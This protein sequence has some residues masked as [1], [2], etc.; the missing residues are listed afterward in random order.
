MSVQLDPR[1]L[2][3]H[4]YLYTGTIATIPAGMQLCDGTNGTVDL[5]NRFVVCADADSGGEAKSTVTGAAAK[6]GNGQLISHDHTTF[7]A[8]MPGGGTYVAGGEGTYK[9]LGQSGG[10]T[11]GAWEPR[12]SLNGTGSVNVAVFYA[13]AFIQR[14]GG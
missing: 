6:S 2:T 13:L 1:Y 5:R 3:K 11:S 9:P 7:S 10:G 14:I 8:S 12:T 4:V